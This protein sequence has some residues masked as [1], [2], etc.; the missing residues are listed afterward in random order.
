MDLNRM[1]NHMALAAYSHK[2]PDSQ[3]IKMAKRYKRK[4]ITPSIKRTLNTVI[5]SAMPSL[6]VKRVHSEVHNV[7]A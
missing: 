3:V 1:T 5:N 2:D 6:L 4:S 7:S